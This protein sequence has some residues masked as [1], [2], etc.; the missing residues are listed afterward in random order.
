[1]KIFYVFNVADV[2]LLQNL[3]MIKYFSN[4]FNLRFNEGN[5]RWLDFY[6]YSLCH[7]VLFVVKVINCGYIY[8]FLVNV[9][10][11]A[12]TFTP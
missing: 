7:T 3:I 8:D 1:M 4:Y 2:G 6:L 10:Y 9:D 5:G 12:N 11:F